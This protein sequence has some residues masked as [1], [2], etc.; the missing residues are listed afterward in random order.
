MG[1]GWECDGYTHGFLGSS[2]SV[3]THGAQF[4][5][6]CEGWEV[7]TV[8]SVIHILYMMESKLREIKKLF[9]CH[10]FIKN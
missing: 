10:N 5:Q 6:I 7:P 3:N 2:F 1:M 8:C 4:S 9:Y